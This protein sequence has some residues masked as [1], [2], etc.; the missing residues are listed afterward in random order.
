MGVYKP[1]S[2]SWTVPPV[3]GAELPGADVA[4]SG[5]RASSSSDQA[6]TAA[7]SPTE[8][9]ADR[10]MAAFGPTL[11]GMTHELRQVAD[12]FTASGK[13]DKPW[14]WIGGALA[15]GY[16]IGRT[17][18]LRP[19]VAYGARTAFTTLLERTLRHD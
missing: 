15:V 13:L 2:G 6:R 5:S 7:S 11:T 19:L 16:L 14:P 4:S 12:R 10:L 3:E 17:R 18:I 8:S 9:V 1:S